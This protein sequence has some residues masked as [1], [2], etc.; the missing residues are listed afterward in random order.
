MIRRPPRSTLFPYTTLFRS[1]HADLVI[2]R[3]RLVAAQTGDPAEDGRAVF[4]LALVGVDLGEV[5]LR[6]RRES[7]GDLGRGELPVAGDCQVSFRGQHAPDL[8]LGLRDP[9]YLA[10][11]AG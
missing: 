7:F 1:V 3:P 5:D 8:T 4:I 2:S 9:G 11:F 10:C 6:Q